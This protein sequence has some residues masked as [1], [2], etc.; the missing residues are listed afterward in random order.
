[1]NRDPINNSERLSLSELSEQI[2][3]IEIS[4]ETRA[5]AGTPNFARPVDPTIE[6]IAAGRRV[7]ME[8]ANWD[9]G[10]IGEVAIGTEVTL[11]TGSENPKLD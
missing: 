5:A 7:E 1:M 2:D 11:G 9:L 4:P 10:E 8:R 6:A 3:E